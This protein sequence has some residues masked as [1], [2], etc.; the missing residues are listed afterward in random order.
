MNFS[1]TLKNII[2]EFDKNKINYALIGG[3]ALGLYNYVRATNDLDFL[4]D[5][6][7]IDKVKNILDNIGY[8]VY[9]ENENVIQFDSADKIIGEIDI[10]IA[11]KKIS[12]SMLKESKK[13][14]V[15]D[16]DFYI[17]VVKVE[18]I[19]GLKLQALVNNSSRYIKEWYDIEMLLNNNRK[20]NWAR[21]KKYFKLFDK[22]K[23]FKELK[24][25]YEK[26]D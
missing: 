5:V 23:E 24:K 18:D 11:R 25:K 16:G 1:F 3:F 14:K 13:I 26:K 22:E 17:K 12:L 6:K 8:K 21:L 2:E 10:I 4:V 15:F 9:F 19:I 7:D 20:I